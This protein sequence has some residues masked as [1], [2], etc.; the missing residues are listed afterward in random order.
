MTSMKEGEVA[1]F[2]LEHLESSKK[3]GIKV[4]KGVEVWV[5]GVDGWRTVI[6]MDCDGLFMK[7]VVQRGQGHS[8]IHMHDE[9]AFRFILRHRDSPACEL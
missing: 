8:R 3:S 2:E 7:E 1:V 5:I 9:V 6:D 4:R